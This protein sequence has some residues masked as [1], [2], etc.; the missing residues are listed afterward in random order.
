MN[1]LLTSAGRH[2][3]LIERFQDVL[4]GSG[5]VLAADAAL[6]LPV[7]NRADGVLPTP[8]AD[9]PDYLKTLLGFCKREHVSLLVPLGDPELALLAEPTTKARFNAVGTT[10]VVSSE[11][12]IGCCLDKWATYKYLCTQELPTP[13]TYRSLAAARAALGKGKLTFPLVL[14]SRWCSA[15]YAAELCYD[16]REL[17]L[18][19]RR[20]HRRLARTLPADAKD[21]RRMHLTLI[22]EFINGRE[23]G[24]DVVNDL[25]GDYVVTL[26]REKLGLRVGETD[27]AVTADA[28]TLG[29]LGEALGKSLGHVGSLEGD[30]LVD[31][32]GIWVIGMKARLG[33]GYA[34]S[35]V[36]G[37]NL[38]AAILAWTK[39]EVPN[40]A[41]LRPE[42][43]VTAAK[44]S[45][46]A[47]VPTTSPPAATF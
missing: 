15:S 12:V 44:Y 2:T 6:G 43:G 46:V 11:A 20:A 26:V 38:P 34:F 42:P 13:E 1:V 36:A 25:Q 9:H 47:H 27:S 39:G 29:G 32:R 41:W 45:G 4:A 3:F 19:Y 30:A 18:S 37:A 16:D 33:D 23:Y 31:D 28:M 35:H 7:S 5:K 24:F 40:E 21:G 10:V 17:E 14:K 8:S 22:Q